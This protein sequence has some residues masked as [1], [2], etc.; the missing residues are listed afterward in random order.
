MSDK[1]PAPAFPQQFIQ[2]ERGVDF[3]FDGYGRG[4]ITIRQYFAAKALQGIMSNPSIVDTFSAH[5]KL[6]K[7]AFILADEMMKA[8][9][10]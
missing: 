9:N 7:Q 1:N 6:A 5:Q 8:E 2:N 10:E 3:P 4:G